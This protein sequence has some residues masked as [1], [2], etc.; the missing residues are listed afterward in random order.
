MAGVAR[1]GRAVRHR[2][3]GRLQVGRVTSAVPAVYPPLRP[4][5]LSEALPMKRRRIAGDIQPDSW[6]PFDTPLRQKVGAPDSRPHRV[7]RRYR[8]AWQ[9]ETQP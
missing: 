1:A 7:P 9:R 4:G 2:L 6:S 3:T 8:A 5:T